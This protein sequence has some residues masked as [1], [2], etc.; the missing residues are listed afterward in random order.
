[1]TVPAKTDKCWLDILTGKKEPALTAL[2]TKLLLQRLRQNVRQDP[3]AASKAVDE[4][5]TFFVTNAF[6]QR[7]IPAL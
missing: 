4:F 2:A 1:M 5:H 6:A 7:D 3:A